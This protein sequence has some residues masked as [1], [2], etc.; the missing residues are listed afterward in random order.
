M[1]RK[2][3]EY[4][5]LIKELNIGT[6]FL[7]LRFEDFL[8]MLAKIHVLPGLNQWRTAVD[9]TLNVWIPQISVKLYFLLRGTGLLNP[10]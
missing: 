2:I 6:N 7:F 1:E 3:C 4:I 5:G 8:L 9:T 10:Y